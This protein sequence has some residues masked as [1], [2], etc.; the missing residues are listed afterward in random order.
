MFAQR[1]GVERRWRGGELWINVATRTATWLIQ[2]PPSGLSAGRLTFALDGSATGILETSG[3]PIG[4]RT[5][6]I[7]LCAGD[8]NGNGHVLASEVTTIARWLGLPAVGSRLFADIDG[9]GIISAADV[10]LATANSD[11]RSW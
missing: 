2:T 5:L 6:S 10:A 3:N 8:F 7:I 1:D 9:N 11:R 4:D